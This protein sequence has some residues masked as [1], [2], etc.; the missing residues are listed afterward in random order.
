MPTNGPSLGESGSDATEAP[1]SNKP[2]VARLPKLVGAGAIIATAVTVAAGCNKDETSSSDTAPDT[3]APSAEN[4]LANAEYCKARNE[5]ADP[6]HDLKARP[7][8]TKTLVRFTDSDGTPRFLELCKTPNGGEF[9]PTDK[10]ECTNNNGD[11]D[12]KV[13]LPGPNGQE[14]VY[15]VED[16]NTITDEAVLKLL[17]HRTVAEINKVYGKLQFV[18][19]SGIQEVPGHLQVALGLW[20]KGEV[21]EEK[22]VVVKPKPTPTVKRKIPNTPKRT[23]D[24]EQNERLTL[25]ELEQ[26]NQ[27]AALAKGVVE[28]G[29]IAS[30]AISNRTIAEDN[31]KAIDLI[32]RTRHTGHDFNSFADQVSGKQK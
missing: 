31:K 1:A 12:C 16:S 25:I 14:Y 26:E 3:T 17:G 7:S 29:R 27:N 24:D 19:T 4:F 30:V 9:I 11:M 18:G 20:R 22:P 5:I 8:G 10:T 6:K 28:R 21:P 13:T 2:L 32:N 23:I 15:M